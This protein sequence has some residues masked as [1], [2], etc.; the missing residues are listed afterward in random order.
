LIRGEGKATGTLPDEAFY[1]AQKCKSTCILAGSDCLK[2]ANEV[3]EYAR[4]QSKNVTVLPIPIHYGT[5]TNDVSINPMISGD[6]GISPDR[7]SLVLFTSGTSG[8]P[9]GVVHKRKYFYT[10]HLRDQEGIFLC[11]HPPYWSRGLITILKRPLSGH[12]IEIVEN[13]PKA[14]WERL[15]SG[16]KYALWSVPRTWTSMQTY[17]NDHLKNLP[18]QELNEYLTGARS[19]TVARVGAAATPR[20]VLDFWA[21]VIGKPL[22][23]SFAATELGGMGMCLSDQQNIGIE[24]RVVS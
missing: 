13:D 22:S 6:M 18:S 4:M 1:L 24:V 2:K 10:D 21:N 7:P 17:F 23:I 20:H 19:L 3:K 11:H 5:Q 12:G 16:E 8:P 14:L 9:K 15:R